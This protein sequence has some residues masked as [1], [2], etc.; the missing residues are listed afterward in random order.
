M[1]NVAVAKTRLAKILNFPIAAFV[2]VM[3]MSEKPIPDSRRLLGCFLFSL[4]F[5]FSIEFIHLFYI[6]FF[7]FFFFLFFTLH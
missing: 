2:E 5:V 3:G 7:F 1:E 4:F 6:F